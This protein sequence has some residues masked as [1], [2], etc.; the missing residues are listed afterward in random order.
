MR[1]EAE[2]RPSAGSRRCFA[3]CAEVLVEQRG[4]PRV[5]VRDQQR[6]VALEHRPRCVQLSQLLPPRDE[7]PVA[8]RTLGR[9]HREIRVVTGLGE[10]ASH[11]PSVAGGGSADI[12]ARPGIRSLI[13][14]RSTPRSP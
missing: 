13:Y 12:G 2:L 1:G 4:V 6:P 3:R 5:K 10:A 7:L 9:C 14:S 11:A 8:R